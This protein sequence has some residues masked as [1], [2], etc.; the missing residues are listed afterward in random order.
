MIHFSGLLSSCIQQNAVLA[1]FHV[2]ISGDLSQLYLQTMLVFHEAMLARFLSCKE[3]NN[4]F[5]Y[6][7]YT[8][9]CYDSE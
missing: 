3:R 2:I 9:F 1:L 8:G 5:K 7:V 6:Q 4:I